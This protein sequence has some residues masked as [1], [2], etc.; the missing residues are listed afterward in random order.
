MPRNGLA[1]DIVSRARTIFRVKTEGLTLI[2][3]ALHGFL[4]EGGAFEELDIRCWLGDGCAA[5]A[6]IVNL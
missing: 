3:C 5:S 6:M 1:E 4:L 2:G